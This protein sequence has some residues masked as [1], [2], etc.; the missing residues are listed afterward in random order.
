MGS[1]FPLGRVSAALAVT[2][3]V[4]LAALPASADTA[5]G[6]VLT[7]GKTEG[8]EVDMGDGPALQE[9]QPTLFSLK[10]ND[11]STLRVYCVE[12]HTSLNHDVD[13][14]EVPWGEYP[15]AESP[16]RANNAKINWVLHNGFPGKGIDELNALPGMVWGESGLEEREAISATQAAVWHFSDAVDLNQE[17]PTPTA[18]DS[19]TDVKA[20]YNYLVGQANTGIEDKPVP[21]LSVSPESADGTAGGLVGPFK[22]STNGPINEIVAD[23]PDD[24]TITDKDGNEIAAEDIEDGTELFLKVPAGAGADDGSFLLRG[25]SQVETGRLF[26]VEDREQKGQSL[27]VADSSDLKVQ[28]GAKGAWKIAPTTTA[29]PSTTTTAPATTPTTVPPTTTTTTAPPVPQAENLPDTGASI[30]VPALVGLGLLGA[31]AG[32]LI[33]VRSRRRSA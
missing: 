16:F 11:G 25:S 13:M 15:A 27:I 26:V 6:R 18:D 22:V 28:A 32:A 23:L 9:I 12:I 17:D 21:E 8:L 24:V 14:V 3:A 5:K 30:L 33:F 2:A 29:P 31:G 4:M 19:A 10:L 20:L 1:R 7:E